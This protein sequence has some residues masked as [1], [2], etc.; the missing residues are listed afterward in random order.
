M[1]TCRV[2]QYRVPEP[3]PES[4]MIGYAVYVRSDVVIQSDTSTLAIVYF[5]CHA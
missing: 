3:E 1:E 5:D 4:M 2:D